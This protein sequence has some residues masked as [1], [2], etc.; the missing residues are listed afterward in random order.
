MMETNFVISGRVAQGKQLGRTLG[1]PTANIESELALDPAFCGVYAAHTQIGGVRYAAVVNIGRHPT[2]PEGPATVEAH[3][4]DFT[5]D[6]Y[7]QELNLTV[8]AHLRGE[9]RFP[10]GQALAKQLRQDIEA[11]KSLIEQDR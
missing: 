6:L 10:D 4:V 7:G 1:F 8:E 2:F 3:L 11:A 9:M 5:G